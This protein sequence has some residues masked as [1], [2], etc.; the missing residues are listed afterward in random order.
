MT[1]NSGGFES[2]QSWVFDR[3]RNRGL[4][5]N[6]ST[7]DSGDWISKT[8]FV[9]VSPQDIK[10]TGTFTVR[11]DAQGK[12]EDQFVY[13]KSARRVRRLSGNAWMDPVGGF[14]FLDDDI[15]VYNARPSQYL[16]NK[17][18]GKRWILASV[19]IN[20]KQDKSKAGTPE[21]WP[22][23]DSKEV[24]HWNVVVPMTPREVW[25]V[26]GTPPNEHPYGKKVMYVDTKLY[27]IYRGEVYDK[28]GEPWRSIDF[29]FGP[30]IGKDSGIKYMWQTTGT[31][32]DFK[33]RHA[34]F[35]ATPSP[36]MD[37]GRS[38]NE[39]TPNALESYQ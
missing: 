32:V 18:I 19:D 8:I 25:V 2:S 3:I 38:T 10:G 20:M 4:L 9:G 31:F 13:I 23:I 39:Y 21:E 14:D 26:E 12:L 6:S 1:F 35:F 36:V 5:G 7:I 27:G 29:F 37:R 15:Y 30:A 24:P 33:A 34:T 28:K 17:L 16:H 11:Y 22:I